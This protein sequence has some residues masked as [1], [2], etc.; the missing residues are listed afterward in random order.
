MATDVCVKLKVSDTKTRIHIRNP[1]QT[2][3]D[4]VP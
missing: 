4:I 1:A 3:L 2:N